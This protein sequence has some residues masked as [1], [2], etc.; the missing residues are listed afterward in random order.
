MNDEEAF[1]KLLN[2]SAIAAKLSNNIITM[3][4]A[5]DHPATGLV[6]LNAVSE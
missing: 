4:V 2:D 1:R 6:I 3:G 5:P